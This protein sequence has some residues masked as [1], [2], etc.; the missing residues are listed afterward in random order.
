MAA[1]VAPF[2]IPLP[3]STTGYQAG[4]ATQTPGNPVALKNQPFLS[5]IPACYRTQSDNLVLPS[6]GDTAWIENELDLER[7]H[8]INHRLW[9][10]GRPTLPRPLHHQILLGREVSVTEQMDMHLVWTAG[11]MYLKPL[12]RFLLEPQFWKE[13]LLCAPNCDC[14]TGNGAPENFATSAPKKAN[15]PKGA[16]TPEE[17]KECKHSKLYK[18]A[19]GFLFSYVALIRHESDLSIAKEK[20]LVPMDVDWPYWTSLVQQLDPEH[21]YPKIDQRFLYGELRLSRLNKIYKLTQKPGLRGYVYAWQT[22]GSFFQEYFGVLAAVT[23]Y[24][25]IILTAM[26]V[27]LA[28]N[29]LKEN[30]GF[31]R[32]SYGF[33][34]LSILGPLAFMA[35]IFLFFLCLFIDNWRATVRF[36]RKRLGTIQPAQ[37][38]DGNAHVTRGV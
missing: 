34:V 20:F 7:L 22:Y 29:Q 38:D 19:L 32:A 2:T 31:H 36:G 12:P 28:T 6:L 26:Q 1:H 35:L 4:N 21:I 16:N 15:K 9:L 14:T 33:T 11:H 23:V 13:Y 3:S 24:V 37:W 17:P 10:V 25:A 18:I 5:M 27:G 30:E 8:R